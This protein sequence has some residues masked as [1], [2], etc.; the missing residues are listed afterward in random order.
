VHKDCS[1]ENHLQILVGPRDQ[2]RGGAVTL[3]A[4]TQ[5]L[6]CGRDPSAGLSIGCQPH[7]LWE[8]LLMDSIPL[9]R[10]ISKQDSFEQVIYYIYILRILGLYI[11]NIVL[12]NLM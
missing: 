8:L 6:L 11:Y 10:I 9:P 3:A 1:S 2:G 4:A 5:G 12:Q 7:C